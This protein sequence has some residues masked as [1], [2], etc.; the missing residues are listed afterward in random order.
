MEL[1]KYYIG[2][3]VSKE[4]LDFALSEAGK[5]IAHCTIGNSTKQIEKLFKQWK[6]EL[7]FKEDQV[8]VCMEHTGVYCYPLIDFLQTT[9]SRICI[10]NAYNIKYSQG[11]QR[12]KNDKIDAGRIALFAW[13]NRESLQQWKGPKPLIKRL[14]YLLMSRKGLINAKKRI[15][16][17]VKETGRFIEKDLAKEMENNCSKSLIAIEKDIKEIEFKMLSIIKQDQELEKM[18]KILISI[19][20]IGKITAAMFLVNTN[21]FTSFTEGKKFACYAGVVPFEH[22]SGKSVRGKTKVSHFANKEM[23]SAL[24][25]CAITLVKSKGDMGEYYR[26]KVAE[27]KNKMSVLNAL[28]NKIVLRTFACIKNDKLYEKKYINIVA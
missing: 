10:E 4:T 1:Q 21:G 11:L 15:Q 5:V 8:L 7:K 16:L 6:K 26:R 9:K 3:D 23:K 25:L 2:V 24:H 14:K 20:G 18:F 28:R 22:S 12:G 13:K 17:S 27:G 19:E